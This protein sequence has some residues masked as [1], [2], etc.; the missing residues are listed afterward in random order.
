MN[1]QPIVISAIVVVTMVAVFGLPIWVAGFLRYRI[2]PPH[3]KITWLGLPL[4]QIRL[5][6]IRSISIKPVSFAERWG[7]TIRSAG[8]LL[9]IRRRSGW[10]K[11]LVITPRNRFMF[12]AELLKACE[13]FKSRP[14]EAAVSAN[15]ILFDRTISGGDPFGQ[16]KSAKNAA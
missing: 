11:N 12:R 7:N 8:R 1:N 15:I 9:V 3:L 14:N 10:R 4:R 2:A 5:D 13:R 16:S 6:D